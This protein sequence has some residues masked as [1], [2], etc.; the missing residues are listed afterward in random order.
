[1]IQ[2]KQS[3]YL[4]ISS[5][6]LGISIVFPFMIYTHP[7][8]EIIL[9]AFAISDSQSLLFT[10][11]TPLYTL[12]VAI[13]L[14]AIASF[15]TIFMYKNRKRQIQIIR[16]SFILKVAILAIIGYLSYIILHNEIEL[17]AK[18]GIGLLL[19][20]ICLVA[21]WLAYKGIKKDEDLIR[22]IDRIR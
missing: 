6:L 9:Q 2:R 16:Y 17:D 10:P 20:V 1:M 14:S 7:T 18:P 22:S 21:D 3:L 13:V 15:S 11:T 12:G 4:L 5:L 19:I 8:A